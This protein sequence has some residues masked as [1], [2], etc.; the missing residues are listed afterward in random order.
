MHCKTTMPTSSPSTTTPRLTKAVGTLAAAAILAAVVGGCGEP[1]G[2]RVDPTRSPERAEQALR[3][4]LDGW[5]AGV[6]PEAMRNE[7]PAI[8]VHDSAWQSGKTLA[9]YTILD[10]S[11]GDVRVDFTVHLVFSNPDQEIDQIYYVWGKTP[12]S[13]YRAEDFQRILATDRP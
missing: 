12:L 2:G 3:T 11:D 7:T 5:K 1:A 6:R 9:D 10:R 13:V 4:V 8:A